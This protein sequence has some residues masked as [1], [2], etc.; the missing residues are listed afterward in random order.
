MGILYSILNY[1]S[2]LIIL[3]NSNVTTAF[4][5]RFITTVGVEICHT[6]PH[7]HY[8]HPCGDVAV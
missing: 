8:M 3:K 4:C 6:L 2:A 5:K 1:R 7:S